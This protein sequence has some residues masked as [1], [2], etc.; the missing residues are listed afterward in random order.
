MVG[1]NNFYFCTLHRLVNKSCP[2]LSHQIL[3]KTTGV[4]LI[5]KNTSF[6][7]YFLEANAQQAGLKQN[8]WMVSSM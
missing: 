7:V 8:N 2:N 6:Q 3:A 4:G 5:F 1:V